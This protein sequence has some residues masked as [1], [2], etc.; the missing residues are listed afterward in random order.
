MVEVLGYEVALNHLLGF[1]G[2]ALVRYFI[3]LFAS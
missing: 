3:I 2:A 1:G